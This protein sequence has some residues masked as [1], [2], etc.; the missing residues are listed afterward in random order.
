[1]LINGAPAVRQGVPAADANARN[2]PQQ[3]N[4]GK[5]MK[6]MT[7]LSARQFAD[8]LRMDNRPVLAFF[9]TPSCEQ[10]S[11]FASTYE[12]LADALHK[13][14]RAVTINLDKS[15]EL[16]IRYGIAKVPALMFF[17]SGVPMASL[18]VDLP[19]HDLE[20]ELEGLLA[21]YATR[22]QTA[23]PPR[24]QH[25]GDFSISTIVGLPFDRAL[26]ET[27]RALEEE[28]FI[29]ITEIDLQAQ[30]AAKLHQH[31]RP[32]TIL[33][34]WVPSWEYEALK[35]EA[36]A[37]LLMPSHVCVWDNGDD[38]CTVATADLKHLCHV[39]NKTP[40]AEAARAVNA[41]LRGA[42][43]SVQFAASANSCRGPARAKC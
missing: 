28:E 1:M 33:G 19:L 4:E 2:A 22:P 21:D 17:D 26:S 40:L 39:E 6:A 31:I 7:E 37:G 16:A 11:A 42:V 27:R 13:Q 35:S 29:I 3:T 23:E 38:T 36:D 18:D 9:C 25:D 10:C 30:L 24:G 5:Y 43:S 15:P 32:Y 8:E 20:A 41:R 14:M 34:V 12:K